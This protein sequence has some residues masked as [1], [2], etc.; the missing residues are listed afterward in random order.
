MAMA[1]WRPRKDPIIW[2]TVEIEAP[3]LLMCGNRV[4]DATGQHV[5]VGHIFCRG[6]VMRGAVNYGTRHSVAI[7]GV[8]TMCAACA[9]P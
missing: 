1:T 4:R 6:G 7:W 2:A 3:R 8:I 9:S 5:T